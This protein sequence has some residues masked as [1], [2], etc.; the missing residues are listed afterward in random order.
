M[1]LWK[2]CVLVFACQTIPAIVAAAR[3]EWTV[4]L[5]LGFTLFGGWAA[6][7]I[8]GFALYEKGF[9]RRT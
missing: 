9:R 6:G 2:I 7:L 8:L 3:S 5:Y 1:R 4:L